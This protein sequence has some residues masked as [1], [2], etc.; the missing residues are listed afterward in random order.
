M[1]MIKGGA[2]MSGLNLSAQVSITERVTIPAGR[3]SGSANV[4]PTSA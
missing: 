1:A 3:G 4:V 2:E